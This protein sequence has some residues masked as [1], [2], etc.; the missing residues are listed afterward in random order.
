[1]SKY[2]SYLLEVTSHSSPQ[3]LK[4]MK[5]LQVSLK[6]SKG[7]SS[8]HECMLIRCVNS[9]IGSLV[10]IEYEMRVGEGLPFAAAREELY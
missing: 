6:P 5:L 2:P 10:E 3:N 9:F 8:T 7:L 4:N 1:M